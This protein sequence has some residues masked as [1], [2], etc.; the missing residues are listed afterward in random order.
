VPGQWLFKTNITTKEIN[1]MRWM[2]ARAT[3]RDLEILIGLFLTTQIFLA[4]RS[5]KGL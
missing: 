2:L 5:P 1:I 3:A 4:S